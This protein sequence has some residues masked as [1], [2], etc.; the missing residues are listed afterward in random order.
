MTWSLAML[1][2]WPS[3]SPKTARSEGDASASL[4][5]VSAHQAATLCPHSHSR[6]NSV[7]P[8]G[9][10]TGG[11]AYRATEAGRPSRWAC[12]RPAGS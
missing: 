6:V 12:Y 4:R 2:C 7:C 11:L 9:A 8:Q 1:T 5:F 3:W 10:V